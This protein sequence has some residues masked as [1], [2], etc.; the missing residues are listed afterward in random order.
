MDDLLHRS[1]VNPRWTRWP[2]QTPCPMLEDVL[3][4]YSERRGI[5]L[6]G[7]VEVDDHR[8]GMILHLFKEDG[9]RVL[10]GG[11]FHGPTGDACKLPILV[12]GFSDSVK[13]TALFEVDQE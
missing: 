7:R 9:V 1:R 10:V 5:H 11:G 6:R 3:G 4:L 12:H 13:T 8:H 2:L